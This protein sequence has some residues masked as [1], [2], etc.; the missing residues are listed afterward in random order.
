MSLTYLKTIYSYTEK[1]KSNV[2]CQPLKQNTFANHT[3]MSIFEVAKRK[4]HESCV[5]VCLFTKS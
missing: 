5:C 2:T 3:F 4:N 1:M